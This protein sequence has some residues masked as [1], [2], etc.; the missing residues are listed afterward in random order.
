MSYKFN[1]DWQAGFR[2]QYASGN[3][4]TEIEDRV[5]LIDKG[6]FV[7]IFSQELFQNRLP[8]THRLDFRVDRTWTFDDWQ[9]LLYGEIWNVYMHQNIL[10]VRYNYDYTERQFVYSF[11]ILPT[12][13]IR[14]VF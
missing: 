6:F 13:G 12:I 8:P 9:L 11:P 5:F 1:R 3:P 10:G 7:P 4:Y 14:G 2:W